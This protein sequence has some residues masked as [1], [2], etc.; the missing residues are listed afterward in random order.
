VGRLRLSIG[1]AGTLLLLVAA[2][3]AWGISGTQYKWRIVRVSAPYRTTGPWKFCAQSH[4]GT[5]TCSRGFTVANTVTGSLGV[6]DDLLSV[7]L[8]Y[9]VTTSTTL[10]GGASFKVPRHKV[11]IAQWRALFD[12]RAVHQRLY[13]RVWGC[14]R[15]SCGHGPWTATN[16]YETAYAS[17]YVGPDFRLVLR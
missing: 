15:A 4:G 5:V 17:R 8:G 9:S 16:R 2:P 13:K 7:T 11:G 6:S 1:L 12:T 14:G 10:T 3:A